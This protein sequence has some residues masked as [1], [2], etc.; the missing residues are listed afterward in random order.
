MRVKNYL[1]A[2]LA[3]LAALLVCRALWTR[4]DEGEQGRAD[5]AKYNYHQQHDYT[6]EY[7]D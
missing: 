4:E 3:F 5:Y 7:E 2:A 6:G 1:I